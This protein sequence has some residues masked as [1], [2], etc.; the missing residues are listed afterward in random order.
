MNSYEHDPHLPRLPVPTLDET[1]DE[2]KKRMKP[3]VCEADFSALCR[4]L[5]RFCAPDGE[6]PVLQERL[7][8]F[9]HALRGNSSWLRPLWDDQY[10]AYQSSLPR[11]MHY[12]LQLRAEKYA[13]NALPHFTAAMACTIQRIRWEHVPPEMAGGAYTSMDTMGGMFYT[14]IPAPQRDVLYYPRLTDPLTAA[15]VCR[16]HW[17]ILS[18]TDDAGIV[19]SPD[20]LQ[21]AFQLIREQAAALSAAPGVGAFTCADRAEALALRGA[22]SHH[23]LNRLSLESVEKAVFAVCL[24]ED[25]AGEV[26]FGHSVLA[27]DASNR[28]FDK[29]LQLISSGERLGASL[30]HAG[31]DGIMFAY[32]L[33]QAD[34]GLLDYSFRYSEDTSPAHVRPLDWFVPAPVAA[35]LGEVQAAFAAWNASICFDETR[36]AALSKATLKQLRCSPDAVVQLLLQTAYY[37]CAGKLPSVYEAVSTRR[38]YAGR[39][40]GIRSATEESLSFIEAFC[41]GQ[42]NAVVEARFRA[43]VAVHSENTARCKAGLGC[44]RHM[45]GLSCMHQMYFPEKELPAV[46]QTAAYRTLKYDT[47]STSSIPGSAV[48]YFAFVPVV[49]DGLGVG[50]ALYDSG[51]HVSVSSYAESGIRPSDFLLALEDAGCKLLALAGL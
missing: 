10:L 44:E 47:L 21:T 4:A 20:T 15:V 48:D 9:Q 26:P 29:S 8:A 11:N 40:E 14:R 16:G 7:L 30:E 25:G 13:P 37:R 3:I 51:L 33:G 39:T 50:Y 42:P 32:I 49:Q 43:A 34:Q 22:L 19:H 27:G 12:T 6:G 45:T 46:F 38:F 2:L 41:T 31:C 23:L 35:K 18:L 28:W 5:E 36:I 1:A 17:F 24:D